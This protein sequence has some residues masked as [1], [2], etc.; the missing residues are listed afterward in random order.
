MEVVGPGAPPSCGVWGHP[1]DVAALRELAA[2]LDN[3]RAW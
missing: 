2:E 3:I 1:D